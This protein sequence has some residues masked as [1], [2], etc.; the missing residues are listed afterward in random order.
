MTLIEEQT[1]MYWICVTLLHFSESKSIEISRKLL[2]RKFQAILLG[3]MGIHLIIQSAIESSV[4][5]IHVLSNLTA[6]VIGVIFVLL[7][8]SRFFGYKKFSL[9]VLWKCY[10]CAV[11]SICSWKWEEANDIGNFV[12]DLTYFEGTLNAILGLLL[13]VVGGFCFSMMRG[14]LVPYQWQVIWTLLL[15]FYLIYRILWYFFAYDYDSQITILDR[16]VSMREENISRNFELILWFGYQM[17]QLLR[18]HK[19][20]E[21]VSKVNIDWK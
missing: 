1:V 21:I 10:N 4:T 13:W 17:Y 14:Y 6:V 18:Y 12:T 7:L 8:N 20:F 11:M 15:I 3:L 2:N 19:Q 9:A 5:V 16:D